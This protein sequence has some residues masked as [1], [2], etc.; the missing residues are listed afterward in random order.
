MNLKILIVFFLPYFSIS[1]IECM[2][3]YF[4]NLGPNPFD[5]NISVHY[6]KLLSSS[7]SNPIRVIFD[8]SSITNG[9][10]KLM[11]T[12]INQKIKWGKH[13]F[14]CRESDII[15]EEKLNSINQTLLN[16]G[17]FLH[18]L[19]K[20]IPETNGIQVSPFRDINCDKANY[21]ADLVI[22]VALRPNS[23]GSKLLGSAFMQQVS[24]E[25]GRPIIGG[26]YLNPFYIPKEP[27][28]VNSLDRFYF[29]VLLHEVVHVLGFSKMAMKYW[30]NR[31]TGK[32]YKEPINKITIKKY[33]K[34]FYLLSTPEAT[35]FAERR[36]GIK[37]FSGN[38]KI[39]IELENVGKGSSILSHPES[40]VYLSE[41]TCGT[42]VGYIFISNLTLCVLYDTGWYDVNFSMAEPYPWGSGQ[43]MLLPP[44][45][46]FPNKPPQLSYPAHYLC[47]PNDK[48]TY[49]NILQHQNITD[50]KGQTQGQ[51]L[52]ETLDSFL[53]HYDFMSKAYC[54]PVAPYNCSSN[55]SSDAEC[56]KMKKFSNPR[57]FAL[58]GDRAEFDYMI[59]KVPNVSLRCNDESL[60]DEFTRQTYGEEYG[61]NSMCAM[62]SLTSKEH[63]GGTKKM[64]PRCYQMLCDIQQRLFINISNHIIQCH[65][66]D[67]NIKLKEFDGVLICP[68]PSN[69]C[70][71][72][73]FF[74]LPS[75]E[76]VKYNNSNF[77]NY[78]Y[79]IAQPLVLGISH[80]EFV[81]AVSIVVFFS[82]IIC[83]MILLAFKT[84]LPS[85]SIFIPIQSVFNQTNSSFLQDTS[86]S[87]GN[88]N[89][90]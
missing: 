42:F 60:N 79:T 83:L 81:I 22:S 11:C 80:K 5:R 71:M 51:N 37:H 86:V 20:V 18:K 63:S 52:N 28:D 2:H 17:K 16:I 33:H 57:N 53:C 21:S 3:E 45:K 30:I 49:N 10:D 34:T 47:W 39:G 43:S 72:K 85:G 48:N 23:P 82:I 40:R 29:T 64:L 13:V 36:F 56:C 90:V 62:S 74:N 4:Q 88:E 69:I 7:D 87:L 41:L 38:N 12:K 27:Q 55:L 65:N 50:I 14:E 70:G 84:S 8:L 26:M 58:R 67:E 73:Q 46:K 15:T 77:S 31:K 78:K 32:H 44:M 59:F 76:Q 25:T 61:V 9:K 66:E 19:L 75:F 54:S 68:K 1:N 35:K 89:D 24:L 6:P